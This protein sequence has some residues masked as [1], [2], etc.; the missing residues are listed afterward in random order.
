M[1]G[2]IMAFNSG[3]LTMNRFDRNTRFFGNE[4]QSRLRSAN[5]V[6]VGAGGLGT[7]VL[8]QLAYM[9]IGALTFIDDEEL[10]TTNKNRYVSAYGADPVPGSRKVDLCERM[11]RL[12]DSSIELTPIFANL[13][14]RSAFDA[15]KHSTHVFGCV[16]NDGA[17]LVLTELCSAYSIPY[18][19]LATEIMPGASP[20][21]GGRICVSWLGDGCAVCLGLL[22]IGG[23]QRDLDT[24]AA[25][26]DRQHLYGVHVQEIDQVGPAVVSLNGVVASLAVS[27]FMAAVTGLRQQKRLLTYRGDLGRVTVSA[28]EPRADC[29]YCHDVLGMR[30]RA[31]S[32]RYINA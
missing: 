21:Y 28:D 16:D 8:Q 3:Q 24:P 6:V 29:Y 23:A 20:I 9:G 10:D 14:S 17:R 18:F 1:Y 30:E 7:H 27:E 25:R 11:V 2:Q 5:V 32:D 22:D 26:L 4:G 19:D 12:I 31:E 13:R 15:V